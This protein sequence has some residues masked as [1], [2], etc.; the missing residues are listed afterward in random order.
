M[1]HDTE[2]SLLSLLTYFATPGL[3]RKEARWLTFCKCWFTRSFSLR[4]VFCVSYFATADS[5][6]PLCTSADN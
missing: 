3:L 4:H 1:S 5:R 2:H 6:F